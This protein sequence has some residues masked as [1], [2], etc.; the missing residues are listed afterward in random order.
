MKK[1]AMLKIA[2]I[3]MVAVLLTTCAI[4][5]T[6]AK[7]VTAGETVTTN[8][9]RVA[10]WGLTITT[11]AEGDVPLFLNSYDAN[12]SA[13][14]KG[15]TASDIV[16]A[17]GTSNADDAFAISITGTPEVSYK[18][19]VEANLQLTGWTVGSGNEYYCPL[20]IT[21]DGT[22]L[23]GNEFGSSAEFETAVENAI[24]DAILGGTNTGTPSGT[25]ANKYA[26]EYGPNVTAYAAS[27]TDATGTV[28]VSWEWCYDDTKLSAEDKAKAALDDA[29]DTLL[30]NNAEANKIMI[31][32]T[33]SAEQ[34]GD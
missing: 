34:V 28:A 31:S 7:Y 18:L 3:L 33:V 4:S 15:A 26:K 23:Y 2:A 14:V 22:T 19:I 24:A 1:N 12:E 20:A 5:S 29:K 9:A 16:V 25:G 27:G 8:Q 10:K 30:G 17:P 6:F 11:S 21:V 13:T 32:Y